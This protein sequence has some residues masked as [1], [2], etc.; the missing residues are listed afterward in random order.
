MKNFIQP[1]GNL[2][3]TA[4]A[5]VA[6]GGGVLV[7][8]LFGVATAA[9]VAGADVTIVRRGVFSLVKTAAQAWAQ[10]AKVYWN[11][12]AKECTTV[13]TGNTL[14]GFAARAEADANV[15][16]YVLLDGAAATT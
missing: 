2:T 7:G 1:G 8:A 10:G 3:V 16:G 4:P 15:T 12:T 9:A 5:D 13:A 11:D 6:S 14:I